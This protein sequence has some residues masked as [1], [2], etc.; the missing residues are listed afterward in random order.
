MNMVITALIAAFIWLILLTLV[1]LDIRAD[2]LE[3]Q[4]RTRR[5]ERSPWN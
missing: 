5:R 3:L 4:Y 1:S 2:I